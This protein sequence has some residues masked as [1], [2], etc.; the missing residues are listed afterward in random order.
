MLIKLELYIYELSGFCCYSPRDIQVDLSWKTGMSCV[1]VKLWHFCKLVKS[2]TTLKIHVLETFAY[3]LF[4]NTRHV[5]KTLQSLGNPFFILDNRSKKSF[6]IWFTGH[7]LN[8]SLTADVFLT[9]F[10]FFSPSS[11]D[12]GEIALFLSGQFIAVVF[13]VSG[14]S[15]SHLSTLLHS[16]QLSIDSVTVKLSRSSRYIQQT[17]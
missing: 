13:G 7:F 9:E 2:C 1:P 6:Q 8:C 14:D 5:P 3:N 12:Q 16:C 15:T 10:G 17:F 4:L 11:K